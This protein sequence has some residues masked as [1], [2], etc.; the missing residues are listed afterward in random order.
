MAAHYHWL[1]Y[2]YCL[3]PNH[4][5]LLIETVEGRLSQGM[6]SPEWRIYPGIGQ[7]IW[8]GLRQQ[9]Y[10]GDEAFVQRMQSRAVVAGDA[11]TVP[12]VQRRPP[13]LLLAEL[14]GH[15][16]GRDEA[17]VAAYATGAYCYREIAEYFGGHLATVGRILRGAMLC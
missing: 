2:A 15:L 10:L 4:Y 7:R 11:S 14:A 12:R 3:M 16:G 8:E 9:I 1:C 17:I 6:T 13:P 5:H